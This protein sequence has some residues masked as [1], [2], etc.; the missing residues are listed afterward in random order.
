MSHI[1][2]GVVSSLTSS[3]TSFLPG[4]SSLLLL[5]V[6]LIVTSSHH[7]AQVHLVPSYFRIDTL[8]GKGMQNAY[9]FIV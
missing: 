3:I 1:L 9:N 5:M 6:I 2:T 7:S 8:V 4:F